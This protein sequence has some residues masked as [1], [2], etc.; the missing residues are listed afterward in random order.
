MTKKELK[1]MGFKICRASY[2]ELQT[3]LHAE[4]VSKIG[5]GS[6]VYGWNWSAYLVPTTNGAPVIVC[7]GYRDLCGER[8][9]GITAFEEKARAIYN[10]GENWQ[11][12]AEKQRANAIAL[13]DYIASKI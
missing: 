6:G 10:A 9:D 12:T 13:G 2:C 7:T 11:T 8:V 4:N 5:S 3:A 1:N